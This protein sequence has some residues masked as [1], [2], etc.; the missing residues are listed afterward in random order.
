MGC[1]HT[2]FSEEHKFTYGEEG[3]KW[4]VTS[5]EGGLYICMLT[6]AVTGNNMEVY[7]VSPVLSNEARERNKGNEFRALA[8]E[9]RDRRA[10][11]DIL[12]GETGRY[13]F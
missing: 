4:A 13:T 1:R 8:Q 12:C 9:G 3:K 5:Y 2:I 10:S 11:R 7:L 6:I